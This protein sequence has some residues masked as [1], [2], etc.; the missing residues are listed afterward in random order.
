MPPKRG[1]R[2]LG[3]KLG[4]PKN[5]GRPV[6]SGLPPQKPP[7]QPHRPAPTPP[8]QPALQRLKF[9]CMCNQT[10]R[11]STAQTGRR[12]SCPSC[13]RRFVISFQRNP[14]TGEQVPAPVYISAPASGQTTIAEAIQPGRT[15][16]TAEIPATPPPDETREAEPT[17]SSLGEAFRDVMEGIDVDDLIPDPPKGLYFICPCGEKL[18][19][20]KDMY[21]RRVRCPH[22]RKRILIS[23]VYDDVAHQY[24]IQPVRLSDDSEEEEKK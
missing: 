18:I 23:L 4:R 7:V 21:D 16:E 15:P 19:A 3:G 14:T 24:D 5:P 10:L 12:A 17:D 13:G 6:R 11:L 9:T 2:S 8:S 20:R 22:C 1:K